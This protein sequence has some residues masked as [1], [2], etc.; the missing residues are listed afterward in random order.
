M[1]KNIYILLFLLFTTLT[2]SQTKKKK[3]TLL[4]RDGTQ[5]SCMARISGE[6]I[7]YVENDTRANEIVVNEKD[8]KGIKIWMN[9]K[10]IELHYKV[11][12]GKT[13]AKLME[14]VIDNNMK[15][16]RISDVYDQNIGFNSTSATE[17]KSS[18]SEYFLES[19]V[20]KEYVI[21][22]S[23][24]FNEVAKAYFADCS[25][26]VDNIGKDKFRKKDI[27]KIVVFYN[28]NC[29]IAK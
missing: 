6:N 25:K 22:F 28:E 9:D 8:L 15:L 29:G 1:K 2:F 3:A 12:E 10:L 5:L 23:K 18:S 11:E 14:L 16:Y 13:K 17:D 19:K 21:R 26:L 27:L 20:N 24:N 7:R 4:F